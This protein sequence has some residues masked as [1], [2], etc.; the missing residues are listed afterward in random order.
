[1]E[2]VKNKLQKVKSVQEA[3]IAGSGQKLKNLDRK[4]LQM[5]DTLKQFPF[6]FENAKSNL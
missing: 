6:D 1:M 4:R 3:E 5:R 2:T